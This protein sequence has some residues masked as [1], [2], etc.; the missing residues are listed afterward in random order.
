MLVREHINACGDINKI[1][2]MRVFPQSLQLAAGLKTM[3]SVLEDLGVNAK[4]E[5][6]PSLLNEER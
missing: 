5:K 2:D 1:R 4:H 3:Q 6:H